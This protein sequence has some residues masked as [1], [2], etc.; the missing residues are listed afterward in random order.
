MLHQQEGLPTKRVRAPGELDVGDMVV[1]DS[2][3]L[4]SGVEVYTYAVVVQ[5]QPLVLVSVD[6]DM[7]WEATIQDRKFTAVGV[8]DDPLIVRCMRRLKQ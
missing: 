8:A 6:A 3:Y 4:R 7:R 5:V 2:G 1:P